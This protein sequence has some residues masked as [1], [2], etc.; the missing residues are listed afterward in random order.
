MNHG[1]L[2]RARKYVAA[3]LATIAREAHTDPLPIVKEAVR[4]ASP[5]VK[6][7]VH[8]KRA[9]ATQIPFALSERQRTRQGLKWI[10]DSAVKRPE[11]GLAG[12]IAREMMDIV[13]GKSNVL[14]K[15]RLQ[16]HQAIINRSNA[17]VR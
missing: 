13:N 15:K 16:H 1:H 4:L 5:D 10:I 7:I 6:I 3:C 8:R 12:K 9:K 17:T 2:H 11:H 14:E